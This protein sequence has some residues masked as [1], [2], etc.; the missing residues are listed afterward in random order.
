MSFVRLRQ[1]VRGLARPAE[2]ATAAGDGPAFGPYRVI[3][4]IGRGAA[5]PVWRARDAAGRLVALKAIS[6]AGQ[7]DEDDA[8]EWRDRFLREAATARR[9]QH[10]G[11]VQ[12][13]DA[14]ESGGWAWIAMELV[15]GPDLGR[16]AQPGRLL[17]WPVLVDRLA[18]AAEALHHAHRQGVVHRDIKPAN[19]LLADGASRVKIADF[20]VARI[21]DAA[22]TRTGVML[23]T[24][25]F[26]APEQ[27]SGAP[28]DARS[29]V[30]AFGVT[31]Y[32]LLTGRLPFEAASLGALMQRIAQERTPDIRDCQPS[33]PPALATIVARATERV[34]EARYA[35]AQALADD[36]R[37]LAATTAAAA[38]AGGPPRAG[39]VN[40]GGPGPA[41]S[42]GKPEVPRHNASDC[43]RP[44]R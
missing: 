29:D 27:L 1:W 22:R 5:G 12:V 44:G 42:T 13:L 23:G 37:H 9:L 24:P 33:L 40:S 6:L 26:M 2:T 7:T 21:A 16:H 11:I 20:G 14:G 18:G 10:P 31:L 39:A 8:D 43:G 34:P 32:Q 15:D 4:E 3:D 36:L 19:L 30:Y 28:V 35:G 25:A 38:E 41:R 17:P